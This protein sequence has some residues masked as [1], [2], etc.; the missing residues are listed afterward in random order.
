MAERQT[1]E[2]GLLGPKKVAEM[3]RR[4]A[5]TIR[6]VPE[7]EF[8][9]TLDLLIAVVLS[10]QTTDKAVNQVTRILWQTCRLPQDY[11]DLGEEQL[12]EIVHP[13][14]LYRHKCQAIL[15]LCRALMERFGG[16]VPDDFDSLISL[17]GVGR[18]TAN[19]VLNVGFGHPVLAVD[20][21][22]FRVANRTGLVRAS[23]PE[24]V[25]EAAMRRIPEAYLA[26]AHHY[27]LLHGRYVCT[28]RRPR[29]GDCVINDLCRKVLN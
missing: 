26:N 13:I 25:E 7:L 29:C 23:T 27:L 2:A 16:E 28:A 24:G 17:P 9:T 6:P 14:G 4:L 1:K 8:S 19:V 11:L 10:A 18:K 21:H 12:R 15:G 5:E 3:F 20:T 22:V